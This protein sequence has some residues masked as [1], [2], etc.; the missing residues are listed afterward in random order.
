MPPTR[1]LF[2]ADADGTVP[3][4][5]WLTELRGTQPKAFDRCL[6]L[7]GR[8]GA[9][10]YEIRR[11]LAAYLGDKVYEL[12]ARLGRVNYRVLYGFPVQEVALLLHAL[13]KEAE[14]PAAD[15]ARAI[16]RLQ[17][18]MGDPGKHTHEEKGF[19]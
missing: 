7:I 19:P 17:R 3:V 10:G 6:F 4:L 15:M 1:M 14:I 13:T 18:S 11:P 8:L 9:L 2:Y 16:R 12:R 5:Q